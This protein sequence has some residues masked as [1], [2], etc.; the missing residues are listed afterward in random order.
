MESVNVTVFFILFSAIYFAWAA[1]GLG[2]SY[3][4]NRISYHITY[5]RNGPNART[6][7]VFGILIANVGLF[8]LSIA[9]GVLMY[10]KRNEY[11]QI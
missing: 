7:N 2:V 4:I 5:A 10:I 11:P 9:S 6:G 8:G 3:L 1:F